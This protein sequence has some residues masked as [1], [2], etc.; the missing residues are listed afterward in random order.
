MVTANLL[1]SA[2]SDTVMHQRA[3]VGMATPP[4]ESGPA[5]LRGG[6]GWRAA[7]LSPLWLLPGWGLVTLTLPLNPF[8]TLAGCVTLALLA[9]CSYTDARY[10]KIRNSATYTA[11]VCALLIAACDTL[12]LRSGLEPD[13]RRTVLGS[14]TL[15]QS[16]LGALLA[17]VI[18]LVIYHIAGGGAGDVKLAAVLGALL[19]PATVIDAILWTYVSAGVAVLVWLIVTVGPVHLV[20]WGVRKV[21]SR[22]LPTRVAP[23][24]GTEQQVLKRKLRL[25]PFFAIGTIAALAGVNEYL[26]AV[27]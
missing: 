21:L 6:P 14:L 25:A 3:E 16:L 24:A 5:P 27:R 10:G 17:F 23:P 9:V 13:V 11:L 4:V 26:I 1:P 2:V 22:I 8:T 18:M 7:L 20:T 15:G 19:G 12:F